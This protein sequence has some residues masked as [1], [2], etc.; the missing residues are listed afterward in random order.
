MTT[1]LLVRH[2]QTEWNRVERFR[3]RLD[4]PL[5]ALGRAQAKALATRLSS[6]PIAGL[7]SSPLG[8][9]HETAEV[10][11]KALDCELEAIPGLIDINYGQWQGLTPSQ[12]AE[13]YP[14]LHTRWL[15][16]PHR[17]RFP[18]GESLDDVRKRATLTLQTLT[19]RHPQETILLV[20]HQVVNRIILCIV[21]GL[22]NSCFWHIVQNNACLNRFHW[23]E[24]LGYSLRLL[25]DTS[26]L[27]GLSSRG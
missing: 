18:E 7:Y 8:R 16:A 20:G 9:A 23:E 4:I 14:E 19:A 27:R 6:L 13:K 1:Y 11:A 25:N 22:P 17:V 3:G 24:G 10:I 2:G 26:H 21:L 5:N 15:K 12:V